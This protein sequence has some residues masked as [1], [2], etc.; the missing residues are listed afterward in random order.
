MDKIFLDR[1]DAG[2]E[3]AGQLLA[4][5]GRPG[6][7]VLGLPRGGVP[8][9]YEVAHALG[10]PLDVFVVRKLG[11]PGHD[12]LAMGAIAS[13]DV[14]VLN[15]PLIRQLGI[16]DDALERVKAH[17]QTELARREF[18]YRGDRPPVDAH[19]SIV[20]L[21]DDGLATGATMLAAVTALRAQH[22]TRIIVAVPVASREACAEL[23][24]A[25]DR[26]VCLS[27]PADFYGVGAWYEDFSQTS[28][29]VVRD[30][31]SQ[32]ALLLPEDS[33]RR[34]GIADGERFPAS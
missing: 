18:A 23:G 34:T 15:K 25:A 17:E 7:I 3:L 9:A 1:R 22:A 2:R 31:L 12:E 5:E 28:D 10:V 30:L 13:G 11:I 20:L 21:V 6:V 29:D 32:A 8:V 4:Y 24:K 14:C 33:R 16:G 27:T 19:G 26:C